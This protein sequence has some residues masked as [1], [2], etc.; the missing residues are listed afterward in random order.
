MYHKLALHVLVAVGEGAHEGFLVGTFLF[1]T[2]AGC[3]DWFL[4]G[5]SGLL[6]ATGVTCLARALDAL[7][8]DA[9]H[10]LGRC[11]LPDGGHLRQVVRA[12]ELA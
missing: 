2:F 12:P 9:R 3:A 11:S 7:G 10:V 1:E 5:A 4:A 6:A 8:H